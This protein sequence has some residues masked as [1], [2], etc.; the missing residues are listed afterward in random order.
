VIGT[1]RRKI[2]V[3]GGTPKTIILRRLRCVECRKIH[4]ELPDMVVPYK[5]Y[6]A[7]TIGKILAGETKEPA[8]VEESTI[9]RIKTWWAALLL[10]FEGVIASLAEKAGV[11]FPA[12][13]SP[14]EIVRAVVNS[15]LWPHTRS[16]FLSG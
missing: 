3:F 12:S 9:W 5:R 16:A 10:Y 15:N 6:C 13:P 2:I 14:K 7:E 4:H 11:A 8:A 1:R